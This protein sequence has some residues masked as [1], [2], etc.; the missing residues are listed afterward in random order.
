MEYNV[1]YLNAHY[2]LITVF[3]IN[4]DK[5]ILDISYNRIATKISIQV[6]LLNG[7]NLS[8]KMKDLLPE[9]LPGFEFS[10]EEIHLSKEQFNENKGDWRPLHYQWLEHLLFSKAEV[11]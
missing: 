4:A 9:V 10:I 11:L 5:Y 2:G 3:L 1:D 8:E 7:N 6:V